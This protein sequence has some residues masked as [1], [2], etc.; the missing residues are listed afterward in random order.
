MLN[1][2]FQLI[3]RTIHDFKGNWYLFLTHSVVFGIKR[4]P[5]ISNNLD[6]FDIPWADKY[7]NLGHILY[8]DVDLKKV[9]FLSHFLN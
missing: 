6:D 3:A 4:D 9:I 5:A 1:P 8:R 7:K 2:Y